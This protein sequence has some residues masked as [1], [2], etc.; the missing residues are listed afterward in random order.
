MIRHCKLECSVDDM[1]RR[2]VVAGLQVLHQLSTAR[3][4]IDLLTWT[5]SGNR[6]GK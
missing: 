1:L 6:L 3:N 2:V 5:S 4:D